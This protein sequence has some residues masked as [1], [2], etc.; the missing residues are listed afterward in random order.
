MDIRKPTRGELENIETGLRLEAL[1]TGMVPRQVR[2]AGD[3]P[4]KIAAAWRNEALKFWLVVGR[5]V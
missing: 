3:D 5:K 4:T 1:E 2:L